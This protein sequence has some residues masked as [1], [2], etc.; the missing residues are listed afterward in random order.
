MKKVFSNTLFVFFS[1]IIALLL[2]EAFLRLTRPHNAFFPLEPNLHVEETFHAAHIFPGLNETFTY[3]T[4]SEGYRSFN[5]FSPNR[6]GILALGGSTTECLILGDQYIW[7]NLL[8]EKLNTSSTKKFTI[9]NVGASGLNSYHHLMQLQVLQKKYSGLKAIMVLVGVN[10]FLSDL[11]N[12]KQVRDSVST[13]KNSFKL[14]PRALKGNWFK[15]TE[16]YMHLRQVKNNWLNN[17]FYDKDV[18]ISN[19]ADYRQDLK[20]LEPVLPLPDLSENLLQYERNID[21]LYNLCLQNDLELI[22]VT[23]P[24]LW[25]ENMSGYEWQLTATGIMKLGNKTY[26]PAAYATGMEMYN[27]VLRGFEGKEKV[28]LVDLSTELPKDT[29]VFFDFCHFNISGSQK[30]A[31]V[32]FSKLL[33]KF[34]P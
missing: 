27:D 5:K 2:A 33:N 6:V 28:S 20:N 14:Y 10:D 13:L 29:T 3:T 32:I 22:L 30:V 7:T 34:T 24:V 11:N 12:A 1:T 31:D 19:I 18:I 16:I 15:R 25:H 23:Q 21:Q 17:R 26:S 8:E 4:N 9:G